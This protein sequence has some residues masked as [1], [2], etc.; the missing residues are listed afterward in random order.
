MTLTEVAG[1]LGINF[2]SLSR[3]E[4]G[5]QT[6]SPKLALQLCRIYNLALEDIYQPSPEDRTA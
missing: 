1:R 5:Q 4:R 6:P 3:I 2:S